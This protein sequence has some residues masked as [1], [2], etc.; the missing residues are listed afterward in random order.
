M[1]RFRGVHHL[2]L[3]TGDM[4]GTIRFWRDLLGLRLVA[5][6]G[7]PG[8]RHYFFELSA[9]DLIAFFEWEGVEPLPD[10]EHGAPVKG[11]FGFDH[12]SLAVE[13]DDDLFELKE[14]LEAAEFWVSEVVDHG[15][16]H[17][18]YSFD[19]N[20]IPIEFSAPVAGLDVRRAPQLKDRS[21]SPLAREGPEPQPGH[22]S[23]AVELGPRSERRIYPAAGSE[24]FH[25]RKEDWRKG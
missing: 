15:F 20:N 11:P 1:S 9:N 21:P 6:L 14:R 4:D 12:V 23:P 17:S 3:A 5:S 2:A 22:F 19:P 18:L 8:Y 10:K 16:F 24:L 7:S 13:C 25:T